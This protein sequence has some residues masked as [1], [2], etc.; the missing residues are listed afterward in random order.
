MKAENED[1]DKAPSADE[2]Q[3]LDAQVH[4]HEVDLNY[5]LSYPLTQKYISLFADGKDLTREEKPPLWEV[6]E[7]CMQEG[8]L[9]QLREGKLDHTLKGKLEGDSEKKTLG[10]GGYGEGVRNDLERAT[11]PQD[12]KKIGKPAVSKTKPNRTNQNVK[13][14]R[15]KIQDSSESEESDGGFFE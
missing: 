6:V 15:A 1:N 9:E 8:T 14:S 12:R 4:E 11:A 10:N 3:Q 13:G 5:A 7:Q 2:L